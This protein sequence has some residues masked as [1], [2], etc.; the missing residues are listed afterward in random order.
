MLA[1]YSPNAFA[2]VMLGRPLAMAPEAAAAAF[3][4]SATLDAS[5]QR[6]RTN[7]SAAPRDR[8]YELA[9]GVA[10]IKIHGQIVNRSSWLSARF[11]LAGFDQIQSA[12][13]AALA[14]PAVRGILLDIDSPGGDLAGATETAAA[15]RA[16]A[17][18]A[19]AA[20]KPV[21]AFVDGCALS[22]AYVAA[23]GASRIYC[24]PSAMLGSI[25]VV[26]LHLDTSAAL[27]SRGVKPTIL[28][29]GAHK[30]DGSH[31]MPL[32]PEAQ[33]RIQGQVA[34]AHDLLLASVGAHRPALGAAGARATEAALYMGDK[35]VTAG[36]ADAV[37]TRASPR[38]YLTAAR[39]A[40]PSLAAARPLTPPSPIGVHAMSPST[41][42][43]SSAVS[44]PIAI[45]PANFTS[46]AAYETARR[47][48]RRVNANALAAQQ[49]NGQSIDELWRETLGAP[50]ASPPPA[51]AASAQAADDIWREVL[52]KHKGGVSSAF[53][54]VY[55]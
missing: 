11:G 17:V 2:A 3:D 51:K 27:A 55:R 14:D 10:T 53:S 16:A 38:A 29:A 5:S 26:Y 35:A 46:R 7:E 6:A 41:T 48:A 30:A 37:G 1:A 42:F 9:D 44:S 39:T 54:E 12:L 34:A 25:G 18:R 28:H 43:A 24:A 32:A 19:A 31:M 13:A 49:L 4:L 8:L 36:L 33:K 52:A 50:A 45:S 21:V 22:A 40:P 15:V 20:K 23:A 47:E